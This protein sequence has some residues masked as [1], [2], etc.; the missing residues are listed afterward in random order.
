[1][2]FSEIF[3]LNDHWRNYINDT[4]TH[5]INVAIGAYR[6]S[7]S[8]SNMMAFAFHLEETD[9]L[10]HLAIAST[11]SLAESILCDNDPDISLSGYF[12]SRFRK[13]KYKG[14]SAAYIKTGK[15][16]KVIV[17]V[18]G[19][20]QNSYK[21]IR[22]LSV[23][24]II[25]EEANLLHSS[26]VDEAL[27][28]ILMA[29]QPKVFVALNPSNPNCFIYKKIDEWRKIPGLCNYNRS[30]LYM[31]PAITPERIKEIIAE[32][33]PDS[34]YYKQFILGE[35]VDVDG[36][37]YNIRDY[38]LI[39]TNTFTYRKYVII[40]DPGIN[41]S[42]TGFV[43]IGLTYNDKDKQNEIHVIKEYF[44]R[45]ADCKNAVGIKLP[46]DYANDLVE[47]YKDVYKLT[48]KYCDVQI[49]RDITFLR[50]LE[51]AF[52]ANR[53]NTNYIS[54]VVKK[55]IAE[56]IKTG[57]NLLYTGKLRFDSNCK[58]TKEHFINAIYDKK[59]YDEGKTERLDD[60]SISNIDMIDAVE[61]GFQYFIN[62]LY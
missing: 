24:S 22:G 10:L 54:Y 45:N 23:G 53:L 50:E 32:Y 30:T 38:N 39:D 43:L 5:K 41:K 52:R 58:Y 26:I 51:I 12:G 21:A 7:K 25:L 4:F 48:G 40:A 44:H 19:S 37:I 14:F 56:R 17:F 46:K 49:D 15:G 13:G 11:S 3:K 35:D 20:M 1:M 34:V 29:K 42:G 8:V 57:I 31:N 55:E 6:S 2:A 9:D 60:P 33:D 62:Y 18:G 59:K 61:Y 36:V 28:R 27:G 16:T 47:F